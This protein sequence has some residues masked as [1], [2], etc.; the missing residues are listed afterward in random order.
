MKRLAEFVFRY[1]VP[2]IIVFI[3]ITLFF[4]FWIKD[5]TV[6]SDAVTYLPAT[7]PAVRLFNHLGEKFKQNDVVLVAVESGDVFTARTVQDVDRLTQAF[8]SVDGVSSV[9][10]LADMMDIRKAPDG[11]IEIGRL[12]EPGNPPSTPEALQALRTRVMENARYRGGIVSNDGRITLIICQINSGT[13]AAATATRIQ[14]AAAGCNVA[15]KLHFGGNPLL[16]A[17][18]STNIYHDLKIL[19]PIVSVLIILT[20]FAAFGT[21]R[22]VLVPLVAVLMSTVW[23]LGLFGLA[24]VPMTML[25]DIIP[26]LLVAL[27]TAP[28]IHILSK[29]DEDVRRYGSATEESR[30]AF[31]EVGIRVILA[32]VTIILGFSSFIMGS[33]LTA[34]RDFGI[35][36]SIGILFS[37]LISI[38]FVPALV[39]S[40]TVRPRRLESFRNRVV[41]AVMARWA[42]AV[43]RRRKAILAAGGVLLLCGLAGIPFIRRECEFTGFL[44]ADNPLRRTEALLQRDFGGSRPLE[45][46]FKGD[47]SDPRVL[48]EMIRAEEFLKREGLARNPL[49]VADLVAEMN[50]M[51]D[52]QK[53]VPDDPAKVANLMFLLEGQDIV[54]GLIDDDKREGQVQAMVGMLETPQLARL[55]NSMDRYVAGI[56]KKLVDVSYTGMPLISWH[57]DRSVLE[58]Q[59]ESLGIALVFI[60]ALLAL[61]LR[62]WRAGI[63]GLAPIVLAIVIMFGLMGIT[64]IPINVATVLVGAIA[65]GIG[66]DYS[67]HFSVRFSTYYRGPESAAEAIRKTIRTTG[68]AIII[69]VLAVTMGFVALLFASLVPLRQFGALTAIVMIASGLGA[70]TL[71][72]A[73]ILSAPSAFV[74]GRRHAH[75]MKDLKEEH[76]EKTESSYPRA[77]PG[78]SGFPGLGTGRGPDAGASPGQN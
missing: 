25:S 22:G 72:P 21:F 14:A 55:V 58:S 7:D 46:D 29:F 41:G 40:I 30:A 67:I 60:F 4:A 39:G 2:I 76:H 36:S 11:G 16:I 43:I 1:R 78:R 54:S 61:K 52:G 45:I 64:G 12:F 34:I 71:L 53:I 6:N 10:S 17:E 75:A 42:E 47:L 65:L 51:V 8:K 24:R 5:I 50:E 38:F 35:F 44:N 48:K 62:S 3:A 20:L 69:N 31:R 57:L 9:I 66:I 33:Y 32:A 15:E 73:L 27:G 23:V 13:R 18:L 77:L 49:S 56:D 70:L 74:G 28:C 63:I 19:I 37:L 59:A 26:A 68:L